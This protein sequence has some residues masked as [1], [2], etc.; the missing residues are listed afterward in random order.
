VEEEEVHKWKW[1]ILIIILF[2]NKRIT[3]ND[4]RGFGEV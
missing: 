3:N 2:S 1:D 4:L